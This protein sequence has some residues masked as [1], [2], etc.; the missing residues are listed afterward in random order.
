MEA[1][2]HQCKSFNIQTYVKQSISTRR[3]LAFLESSVCLK[4]LKS[5]FTQLAEAKKFV[6]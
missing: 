4:S 1:C 3:S 2:L 5:K 6:L